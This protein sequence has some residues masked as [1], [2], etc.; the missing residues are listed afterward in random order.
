LRLRGLDESRRY[1]VTFN[2]SGQTRV[3]EGFLLLEQGITV[4]L[5][6]ALTSELLV[7]E[8]A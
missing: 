1:R 3:V 2:N 4:C 6:G 7:L 8:V 5:E